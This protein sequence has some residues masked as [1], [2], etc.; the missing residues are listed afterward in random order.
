MSLIQVTDLFIYL[1][2]KHDPVFEHATFQLDTDWKLGFT[3][4]KRAGEDYIFKS[5]YEPDGIYRKYCIKRHI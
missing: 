2:R 3:G 1:R 5:S 4:R